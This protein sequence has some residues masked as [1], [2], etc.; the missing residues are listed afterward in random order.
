MD[1][2]NQVFA[3]N[4][5]N[6]EIKPAYVY[7]TIPAE[8]VCVYHKL[9]VYMADY[10]KTIIDDC[11][12]V[13]KGNGKQILNCWNLFQSA[14]ASKELGNDK[15]ADLFIDYINKQLDSSYRGT[16]NKVYDSVFPVTIDDE[17]NLK[18]FV[19]CGNETKFEVD[20]ETGELYQ[21]WLDEKDDGKV[22]TIDDNELIVNK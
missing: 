6:I 8:Y 16:D 17:G 1:N 2:Y 21:K 4:S 20:P 7:L 18:A 15:Q 13:C 11:N 10:G 5:N 12:A 22:Y 3:K 19:T 14:I 9:L